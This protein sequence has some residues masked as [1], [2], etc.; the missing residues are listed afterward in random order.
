VAGRQPG[1]SARC[2]RGLWAIK[3]KNGGKFPTHAKKA[4]VAAAAEG[5]PAKFYPAEDV[6]KPLAR[7]VIRCAPRAAG[8]YFGGSCLYAWALLPTEVCWGASSDVEKVPAWGQ[9]GR[10]A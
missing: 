7:N 2:R 9:E 8:R 4:A 5:K 3:K 10:R 6:P 1:R